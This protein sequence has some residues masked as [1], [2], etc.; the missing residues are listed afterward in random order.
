MVTEINL[1]ES[2]NKK[3]IRILIEGGRLFSVNFILILIK[4]LKKNLLNRNVKRLAVHNK[5]SNIPASTQSNL[6]LIYEN[7]M[8]LI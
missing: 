4:S 5:W 2:T 6:Q 1:I 8:L 7:R 3:A